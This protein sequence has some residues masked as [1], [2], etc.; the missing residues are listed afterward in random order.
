MLNSLENRKLKLKLRKEAKKEILIE[1]DS[2]IKNNLY[3]KDL[4]ICNKKLEDIL[5]GKIKKENEE[6]IY[7]EKKELLECKKIK[8]NFDK[9]KKTCFFF[10]F[11]KKLKKFVR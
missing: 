4:E 3:K 7:K 10:K 9:V 11:L 6:K 2:L 5:L 1:K 8:R